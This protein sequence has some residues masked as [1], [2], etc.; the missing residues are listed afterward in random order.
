MKVRAAAAQSLSSL[1]RNIFH[2]RT[3][4]A[5]EKAKLYYQGIHTGHFSNT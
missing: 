1:C 3:N 2:D 4:L 5:Y